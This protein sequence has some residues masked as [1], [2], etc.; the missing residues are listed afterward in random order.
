M[1]IAPKRRG[2]RMLL[3]AGFVIRSGA[4]ILY[5][6]PA[7]ISLLLPVPLYSQADPD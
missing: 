4:A 2:R 7:P 1:K 6:F 5:P 3:G